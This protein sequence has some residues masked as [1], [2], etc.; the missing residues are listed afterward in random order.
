MPLPRLRDTVTF[1]DVRIIFK[2]F[3]GR[4]DDYNPKGG[5]RAFSVMLG[6]EEALALEKDRWNVKP[7]KRREEDEEQYYHLKVAVNFDNR[8]PRIWLVTGQ[9]THRTMLDAD[10]VQALDVLEPTK[11]DLEIVAYD[12]ELR[13]GASGRKAYLSTLFFHPYESPLE[14]EYSTVQEITHDGPRLELGSTPHYDLEG[15]VVDEDPAF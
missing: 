5:V 1:R 4:P 10:A 15:T 2:N 14:L 9:G 12:W 8:P 13:T 11:V 7:M 3:S 6:E